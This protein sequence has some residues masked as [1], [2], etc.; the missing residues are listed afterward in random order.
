MCIRDRLAMLAS[1]LIVPSVSADGHDLEISGSGDAAVTSYASQYGTAEFAISISSM[2]ESA[3]NNVAIDASAYWGEDD[4]GDPIIT[5]A[6]V[7]DCS[8]GDADT[9]FGEGGTI[10]A[11][12]Y[13]D[14][15]EGGANIGDSAPV[16]VSVTSDED[17]T[18]DSIEFTVQVSNWMA[19][20]AD[21]AQSYAEGD[22]NQYTISVK[23]IKIDEDGNP[24]AI[25]D[26]ITIG[27][28]TIGSGW[29]IDSENHIQKEAAKRMAINMPIQGTAAEMIKLAMLDIHRTLANEGYETHMILQI[30][31]ELLFEAPAQEIDELQEMVSD[32]M[33]NAMP[34]TVPLVVDCGNGVSWFEAH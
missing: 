12:V 11:C 25:S 3:H 10:D 34:L 32:K 31:D 28:S 33:V 29:N 14:V 15:A 18:G 16:T 5:G 13:V 24:D 1:V 19:A 8:D 6:S 21:D 7:T 23:N 26:T 9:D 30:H 20:S 27:L 22:T 2:T 17:S 4:N